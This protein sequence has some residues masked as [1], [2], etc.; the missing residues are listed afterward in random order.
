LT[1]EVQAQ[2]HNQDYGQAVLNGYVKEKKDNGS[3]VASLAS[4][5]VKV[6]APAVMSL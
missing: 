6:K 1:S 5:P 3:P 4:V 2:T